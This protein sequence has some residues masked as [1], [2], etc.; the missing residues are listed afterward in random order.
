MRDRGY[1][2]G[3]RDGDAIPSGE[4]I[5]DVL[6]LLEDGAVIA[7]GV[8]AA[9]AAL[10]KLRASGKYADDPSALAGVSIEGA[11][12]FSRY[13]GPHTTAFAW[14]TPILKG[15]SAR[16][17]SPPNPRFQRSTRR[18]AF[19]LLHLTPFNS[20]PTSLRADPRPSAVNVA[21]KTLKRWLSFPTTWGPTEWGP[22]PYLPSHDVL[23]RKMERAWG[24]LESYAGLCTTPGGK[25]SFVAGGARGKRLRR[26]PTRVGRR[27]CVLPHTG[28]HTTALARWTP[29]LKEFLCPAFLS[30]QGP[31]LTIPD[32]PRRLSTPF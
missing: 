21:P 23:V 24:P 25:G 31:S 17:L 2:L 13:T 16:R 14:R 4:A 19:Q 20:A 27:R 28:P 7:G 32:T 18:V 1:D 9:E 26:R 10:E 22:M 8:P 12:V 5:V 3:I 30:A 29:F 6:R 11:S 15:F